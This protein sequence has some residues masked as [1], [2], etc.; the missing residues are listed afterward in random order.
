MN[1]FPR[2]TRKLGSLGCLV[3]EDKEKKK[4]TIKS[5]PANNIS[6]FVTYNL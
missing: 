5:I 4:E 3:Y 1:D 6:L 2:K